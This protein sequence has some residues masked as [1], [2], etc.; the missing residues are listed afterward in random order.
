MAE[1]WAPRCAVRRTG[2]TPRTNGPPASATATC[3]STGL[4]CPSQNTFCA[5]ACQRRGTP[6]DLP[7]SP[8]YAAHVAA[9]GQLGSASQ[10]FSSRRVFTLARERDLDLD[11]HVDENGNARAR[12][13]R[14]VALKATEHGYEGRVVAGHCWCALART[15][16]PIAPRDL[17]HLLTC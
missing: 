1:C 10:G 13:L 15:R 4:L 16:S 11:F 17:T 9:R 7:D 8:E 5:L 6:T 12:G 14:Y 2:A 3:Y